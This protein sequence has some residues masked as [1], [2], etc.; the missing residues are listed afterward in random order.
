MR[1]TLSRP[2][3]RSRRAKP[4]RSAKRETKYTAARKAP[5][6]KAEN[7]K[8]FLRMVIEEFGVAEAGKLPIPAFDSANDSRSKWALRTSGARTSPCRV[9]DVRIA[10]PTLTFQKRFCVLGG[11]RS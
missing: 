2:D 4:L 10:T 1:R 7:K 11:A 5:R 8:I 3:A 9:I 6:A